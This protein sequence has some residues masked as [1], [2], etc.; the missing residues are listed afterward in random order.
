MTGLTSKRSVATAPGVS[1][2]YSDHTSAEATSPADHT[3]F[4]LRRVGPGEAGNAAVPS[5]IVGRGLQSPPSGA[6]EASNAAVPSGI[7]ERAR[8]GGEAS[9]GRDPAVKERGF[10]G[11]LTH[12][13]W[14]ILSC[15]PP[16]E[17]QDRA[18]PHD[19]LREQAYARLRSQ[20]VSED[21]IEQMREEQRPAEELY[22]WKRRH[23]GGLSKDKIEDEIKQMREQ[24]RQRDRDGMRAPLRGDMPTDD[25]SWFYERAAIVQELLEWPIP[26]SLARAELEIRWQRIADTMARLNANSASHDPVALEQAHVTINKLRQGSSATMTRGQDR[27]AEAE[28]A[29]QN[30]TR[31]DGMV[32]DWARSDTPI[33]L[34]RIQ[35]INRILDNGLEHNGG[36]PGE[37]RDAETSAG[38]MG[39]GMFVPPEDLLNQMQRFLEWYHANEATMPAIELAALSYQRLVSIHPFMDANGRTCRFVM[40][41][42]LLRHG[43]PLPAFAAREEQVAMFWSDAYNEGRGEGIGRPATTVTAVAQ[44]TTAIERSL[45]ILVQA[46]EPGM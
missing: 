44:V 14:R 9:S 45:A 34:A 5:G 43:L 31:A 39:R 17:G 19:E 27:S 8:R 28:L 32:R 33:T 18:A 35:A 36:R 42:I 11:S 6:G 16:R 13:A 38:G 29:K 20:G 30:W 41:W 23:R 25:Y 2:A 40:E 37:L 24:D 7:V 1:S 26:R 46:V 12:A 21:E 3:T 4:L 15:N 10:I 22:A